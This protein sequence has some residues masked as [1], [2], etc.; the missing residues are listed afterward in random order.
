MRIEREHGNART[1]NIEI[2]LERIVENSQFFLNQILGDGF[3]HFGYGQMNGN[4]CH[5][6]F[7]AKKHHQRLATLTHAG[8]EILGVTGEIEF[9]TLNIFFADGCRNDGVDFAI[10]QVGDGY[11]ESQKSSLSGLLISFAQFHL[12]LIRTHLHHIGQIFLQVIHRLHIIRLK[13]LNTN[14]L[15]VI[16]HNFRRTINHRGAELEHGGIGKSF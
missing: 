11:L 7:L 16:T 15:A 3:R 1:L 2:A 12:H 14:C 13:S 10:F 9:G 6:N 5:T 8:L 4:Q